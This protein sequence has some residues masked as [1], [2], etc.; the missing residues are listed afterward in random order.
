MPAYLGAPAGPKVGTT[1]HPPAVPLTTRGR[2]RG[3]H[4]NGGMAQAEASQRSNTQRKGRKDSMWA[5]RRQQR[6][7]GRKGGTRGEIHW[8]QRLILAIR[9]VSTFIHHIPAGGARQKGG[10]GRA[11][12]GRAR[13]RREGEGRIG[14]RGVQHR[15]LHQ[16]GGGG[17]SRGGVPAVTAVMKE[18]RIVGL[19]P[20]YQPRHTLPYV[21][22]GGSV[23][24]PVIHKQSDVSLSVAAA[25]QVSDHQQQHS[26]NTQKG[27][28][29]TAGYEKE[30]TFKQMRTTSSCTPRRCGSLAALLSV[31]RS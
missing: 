15:P 9:L 12:E 2:Q 25:Q 19:G 29:G 10:R 30:E 26:R 20:F 17:G 21:V 24:L 13:K 23:V 31:P 4:T 28:A 22:V 16:G 3:E 6:Q 7:G 14:K 1:H 18:E 8:H 5:N 27:S 11:K